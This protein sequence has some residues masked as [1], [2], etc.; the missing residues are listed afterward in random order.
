[1][2]LPLH[3]MPVSAQ[4]D[5]TLRCP[6]SRE[7]PLFFMLIRR[8]GQGKKSMPYKGFRVEKGRI[9]PWPLAAEMNPFTVAGASNHVR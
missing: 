1:M 4:A 7:T 8:C 3:Q 6:E 5:S 2:G 9:M